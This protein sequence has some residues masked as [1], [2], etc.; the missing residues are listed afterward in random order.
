M[1]QHRAEERQSQR[2]KSTHHGHGGRSCGASLFDVCLC[3]LC[4]ALYT[5]VPSAVCV[6]A[7]RPR[8][9][10]RAS[11][12]GR[13]HTQMSDHTLDVLHVDQEQDPTR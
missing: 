7:A 5:M 9:A 12:R 4:L 13:P 2:G 6:H 8:R 3:D 10:A 11:G 1:S